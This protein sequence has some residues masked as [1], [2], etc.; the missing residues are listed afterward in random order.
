MAQAQMTYDTLINQIGKLQ[1]QADNLRKSE[2]QSAIQGI[3]EQMKK[4]NLSFKDLG[5]TGSGR[6]RKAG[7][8][9]GQQKQAQANASENS[10]KARQGR[11]VTAKFR[12]P[13][14]GVTWSG[15]G[16]MPKWISEAVQQGHTKEEFAIR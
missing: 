12:H 1:A 15:R 13:E 7:S 2:V 4:Y 16:R 8:G 14:T 10:P 3:Q 9:Q 11:K 6:G 5:G